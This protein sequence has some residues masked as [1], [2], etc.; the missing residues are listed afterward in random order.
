MSFLQD[1]RLISQVEDDDSELFGENYAQGYVKSLLRQPKSQMNPVKLPNNNEHYDIY[2][3]KTLYPVLLP[4]V[5]ALSKEYDRQQ[6]EYSKYAFL[7]TV[8]ESI[9][10][11]IRKRFNP[12]IFRAEYLMR[13]NPKHGTKLEY[14][15]MFEKFARVEKLRRFFMMKKTYI[16]SQ[17]NR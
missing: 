4:A 10:E 13:N 12:C 8:A 11:S 6:L 17:F 16:S 14:S 9:D 15:E 3:G 7:L 2:L 5:E 1:K